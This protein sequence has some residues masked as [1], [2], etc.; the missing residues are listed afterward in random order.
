M[1]GTFGMGWRSNL[2]LS[3]LRVSA[4][5]PESVAEAILRLLEQ[6]LMQWIQQMRLPITISMQPLRGAIFCTL[7]V[8]K[9]MFTKSKSER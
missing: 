1:D 2:G 6:I 8:L 7:S 3:S 9:T 5:W 4:L